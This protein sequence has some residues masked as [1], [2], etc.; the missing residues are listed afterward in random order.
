MSA[1]LSRANLNAEKMAAK[2][3][4]IISTMDSKRCVIPD[5]TPIFAVFL[6]F[7]SFAGRTW[8]KGCVAFCS[9]GV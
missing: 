3:P 5:V 9:V 1:A 2:T 6:F 8:R 7:L 4:C